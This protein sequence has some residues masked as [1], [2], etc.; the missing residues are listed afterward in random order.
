M[1]NNQINILS[2]FANL[3][4]NRQTQLSGASSSRNMMNSMGEKLEE[5]VKDLFCNSFGDTEQ[6]KIQKHSQCFS[7]LGNQN[8][9]PDIII[10]NG[11]AIEVKKIENQNSQLALNSSCPKDVLH[12]DDVRINKRCRECEDWNEKDIFY[13][14]G[15][16]GKNDVLEHIWIVQG[17][18]YAASKEIYTEI[19]NTISY[20]I[21]NI[22]DVEFAE[23]NEL[24][25]INKI[26]PLGITY[27]RVRGMWGIDNPASVFQYLSQSNDKM[28][29]LLLLTEKYNSLPEYSRNNIRTLE[30]SQIGLTMS[31]V[32]IKDPNNPANLLDAKLLSLL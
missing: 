14:V 26:D 4:T 28:A 6:I 32:Q 22:S 13:I 24:A 12:S 10:K 7:Y 19:S 20:G 16:V 27:L 1:S 30:E 15:H 2:A 29:N 21:N 8:N 25:R 17:K 23:T 5:Y 9:P 3:A 11:D 18:C 31:D